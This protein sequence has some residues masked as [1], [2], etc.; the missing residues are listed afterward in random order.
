MTEI[1]EAYLRR[2]PNL[3]A[4]IHRATQN[5]H[6]SGPN[7]RRQWIACNGRVALYESTI[8]GHLDQRVHSLCIRS[9]NKIASIAPGVRWKGFLLANAAASQR[10]AASAGSIL[11]LRWRTYRCLTT[12]SR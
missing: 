7:R 10:E 12:R 9:D 11:A 3:P 5:L 6:H 4:L 1:V 2:K 8:R